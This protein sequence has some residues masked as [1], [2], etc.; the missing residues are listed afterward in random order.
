M[1][2]LA[3]KL[4]PYLMRA[5]ETYEA[6]WQEAP[7]MDAKGFTAFHSAAKAALSHIMLLGRLI[8]FDETLDT[9]SADTTLTDWIQ[10]AKS[11]APSFLENDFDDSTDDKDFDTETAGIIA[12]RVCVGLG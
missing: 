8:R 10:K 4:N 6:L 9:L 5:L 1:P 11:A 7:P 2:D 12:D 3:V